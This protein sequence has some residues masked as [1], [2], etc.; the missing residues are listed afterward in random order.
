MIAEIPS[1]TDVLTSFYSIPSFEKFYWSIAHHYYY[2]PKSI[3]Y[4]MNELN[5]RYSIEPEQRYDL[6]NHITW[7]MDGKPGGQGRFKLF[8]NKTL[9][10]YK[11][12]L[13][14][15]WKCDTLVLKIFKD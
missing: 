8:S 10:A 2:N 7:L 15:N 14:D 11:K 9:E 13:I 1:S 4:I 12:D 6:S 3:E 5:Y